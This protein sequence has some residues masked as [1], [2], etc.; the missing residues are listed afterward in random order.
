MPLRVMLAHYR[1]FVG[2]N[3]HV[4]IKVVGFGTGGV[5][6]DRVH[7]DGNAISL[8]E[9]SVGLTLF[10]GNFIRT[11]S[12]FEAEVLVLS[13]S[14]PN[15]DW[16]NVHWN[17]LR[18]GVLGNGHLR[19]TEL[20]LLVKQCVALDTGGQVEVRFDVNGY[21]LSLDTAVQHDGAGD[22][23]SNILKH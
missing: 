23:D 6:G 10:D 19:A 17:T 13:A 9:V 2:A 5:H 12:H 20:E 3:L 15:D 7:V 11:D 14:R 8:G 21:A 18:K 4:K 22:S 16:V 1:D